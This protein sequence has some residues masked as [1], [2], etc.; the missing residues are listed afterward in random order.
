MIKALIA[1]V[2]FLKDEIGLLVEILVLVH[3]CL[4]RKHPIGPRL[5]HGRLE[6]EFDSL[7]VRLLDD[8]KIDQ[9]LVN[10]VLAFRNTSHLVV[11][12]RLL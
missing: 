7:L 10:S 1:A 8:I 2:S 9:P 6:S 3:L 4:K 11:H 5:P 12:F